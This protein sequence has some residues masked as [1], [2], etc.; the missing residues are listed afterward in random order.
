MGAIWL[1]LPGE[2]PGRHAQQLTVLDAER[3]GSVPDQRARARALDHHA[4]VPL[5]AVAA[6]HGCSAARVV[7]HGGVRGPAPRCSI[8]TRA[9][10]SSATGSPTTTQSSCSRCWPSAAIASGD[11]SR[12]L[13]RSRAGQRVRRRDLR[14]PAIRGVLLPGQHAAHR[15]SAGLSVPHLAF[16]PSGVTE[17][18][19][20]ITIFLILLGV[21]LWSPRTGTLASFSMTASGPHLPK[22]V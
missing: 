18:V 17:R 4:R 12:S 5:A 14:S 10:S 7:D 1:P 15:L 19:L 6:A 16:T 2:K 22:I 13:L 8:R 11:C 9:G 21:S 20:L 3:S